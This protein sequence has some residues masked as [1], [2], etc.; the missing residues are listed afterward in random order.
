MDNKDIE[1]V[2]G[3]VKYKTRYQKLKSK[4]M[5][6]TAIATAT[7]GEY[8]GMLG[9]IKDNSY[10]MVQFEDHLGRTLAHYA[11]CISPRSHAL[12]MLTDMVNCF[13]QTF[14]FFFLKNN[15]KKTK[16]EKQKINQK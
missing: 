3:I 1:N 6:A 13:C 16:N 4:K 2:K 12:Q 9:G 7:K 11:A 5:A 14:F 15:T 8:S 10:A